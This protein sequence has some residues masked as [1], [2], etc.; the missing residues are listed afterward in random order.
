MTYDKKEID[1]ILVLDDKPILAVEAKLNAGKVPPQMQKLR[2]IHNENFPV[3]QVVNQPG[4]LLK[5]KEGQ[6]IVGCDR[7]MM[8]L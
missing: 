2:E 5:K 6:Y 3:I 1:F 4:V 7:L 8:I